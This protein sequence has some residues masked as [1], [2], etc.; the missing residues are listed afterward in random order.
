M[1]IDEMTFAQE[2]ECEFLDDSDSFFPY[3]IVEP[4]LRIPNEDFEYPQLERDPSCRY[5]M[6]V[7]WAKI[8]DFTVAI[9]L[10]E[11]HTKMLTM[12]QMLRIK[13]VNYEDQIEMIAS[14]YNDYRPT[15][16]VTDKTTHGEQLLEKLLNKGIPAIGADFNS[17]KFDIMTNLQNLLR[18]KRLI[19]PD[20]PV[21]RT[22]FRN[23]KAQILASG[24]IKLG[25][26]GK[27]HDDI[28]TAL[29]LAAYGARRL[30]FVHTAY[31]KSAKAKRRRWLLS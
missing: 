31:C 1:N 13:G 5:Y 25:A 24:H 19:I 8:Q 10:K 12:V 15:K 23:Y 2:Y 14:I 27:K 17:E 21:I 16:I 26:K 29:G 28:V 3:E 11:D 6:G 30:G 9:V 20:L 4:C 18:N 7:D 22:E